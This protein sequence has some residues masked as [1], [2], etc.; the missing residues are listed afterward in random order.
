MTGK[1]K[2]TFSRGFS[3]GDFFGLVNVSSQHPWINPFQSAVSDKTESF[4]SIKIREK[5]KDVPH[6]A[7]AAFSTISTMNFVRIQLFDIFCCAKWNNM[8]PQT[9]YLIAVVQ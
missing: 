4:V 5:K 9:D 7:N 8:E 2:N 3:T 6:F 1:K